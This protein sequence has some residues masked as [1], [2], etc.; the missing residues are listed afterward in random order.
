MVTAANHGVVRYIGK[1]DVKKNLT[2]A[3][4]HF[5]LNGS[6]GSL[7]CTLPMTMGVYLPVEKPLDP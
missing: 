7:S 1:L 2:Q 4:L 5:L 6:F 3:A